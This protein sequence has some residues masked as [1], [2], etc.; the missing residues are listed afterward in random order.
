MEA[1]AF[2]TNPDY[3]VALCIFIPRILLLSVSC[4][5][6]YIV[7]AAL[8]FSNEMEVSD[9]QGD[10]SLLLCV[11]CVATLCAVHAEFQ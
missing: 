11:Q 4:S 10:R 2:Y 1:I 7:S 8:P 5:F 6:L 9:D 3:F